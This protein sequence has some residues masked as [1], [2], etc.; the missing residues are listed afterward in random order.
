[1]NAESLAKTP[2][3][4]EE[5]YSMW[6]SCLS[7]CFAFQAAF[8]SLESPTWCRRLIVEI[9]LC[10]M[11]YFSIRIIVN[12]LYQL[13][14]DIYIEAKQRLIIILKLLFFYE[15]MINI[16]A[17]FEKALVPQVPIEPFYNITKLCC[18]ISVEG[19]IC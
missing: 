1:M 3:G 9:L 10:L 4:S 8:I 19:Y 7:L 18:E 15:L 2:H 13:Y 12:V 16:C 11:G 6:Y 5:G 17:N 14:I